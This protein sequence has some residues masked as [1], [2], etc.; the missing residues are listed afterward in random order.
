[1]FGVAALLGL[2]NSLSRKQMS[3]LVAK[4]KSIRSIR[5]KRLN[6][7][8]LAVGSTTPSSRKLRKEKSALYQD[9]SYR[10]LLK[11]KVV[12]CVYLGIEGRGH[13]QGR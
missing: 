7:G 8:S 4:K 3:H 6:L 5:L 13:K 12:L 10:T 9:L 2:G 1:M 11:T